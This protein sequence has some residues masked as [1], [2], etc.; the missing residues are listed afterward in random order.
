MTIAP[1]ARRPGRGDRPPVHPALRSGS[2]QAPGSSSPR[3]QRIRGGPRQASAAP[4]RAGDELIVVVSSYHAGGSGTARRYLVRRGRHVAGRFVIR[5][6]TV[7]RG[8][9]GG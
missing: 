9:T 4:S 3:D 2:R 5:G 8:G 1:A 7:V 6:A